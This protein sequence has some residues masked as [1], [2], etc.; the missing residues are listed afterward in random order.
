MSYDQIP[1]LLKISARRYPGY[2]CLDTIVL[3]SA[4]QAGR[5]GQTLPTEESQ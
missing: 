3:F 4:D 1:L 2:R 5:L